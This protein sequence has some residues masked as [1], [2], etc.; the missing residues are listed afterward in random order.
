MIFSFLNLL[1]CKEHYKEF[2][3]FYVINPNLKTNMQIY[4]K[5]ERN[6]NIKFI[7][8]PKLSI[9]AKKKKIWNKDDC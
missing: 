5:K 6:S 3:K 7:K 4:P 8:L 1:Y 2:I 9:S